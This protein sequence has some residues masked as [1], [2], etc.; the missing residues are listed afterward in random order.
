MNCSFTDA[1]RIVTSDK[2]KRPSTLRNVW[3]WWKEVA[4]KIG[5]V[6]ARVLLALFYCIVLGPF[7]VALR[8]GSDPL[9]IKNGAQRGWLPREEKEG[10][11]MERARRQF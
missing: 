5:D 2:T 7:A 3:E 1:K 9:A 6:Q 10:T 11:S 8:W 4:K